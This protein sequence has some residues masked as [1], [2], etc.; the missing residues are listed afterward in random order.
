M[1]LTRHSVPRLTG[2]ALI[3]IA[4][5][6]LSNSLDGW[7]LGKV[8]DTLSSHT[9]SAVTRVLGQGEFPFSTSPM[10][11][12]WAA[13]CCCRTCGALRRAPKHRPRPESP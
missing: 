5:G 12:S 6:A 2:L 11:G 3:L 7:R 4:A 9:L 13:C 8:M 10:S 1:Y